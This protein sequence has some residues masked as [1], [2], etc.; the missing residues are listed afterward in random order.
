MKTPLWQ[1]TEERK[2]QANMTGFIRFVN[3]KHGLGLDGY[4]ELYGWS[5]A[6]IPDFWAAMWEFAGIRASRPYDRVVDDLAKFPGAKWFEGARLNFAQNLLRCRDDRTALIF[7]GET[8]KSE[9][10]TYAELYRAVSRLAGSL[11]ENGLQPGDRVAAY[12]PNLK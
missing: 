4:D 2:Q 6:K 12:L 8:Q 11:R 7:R 1:P 10:M 5:V 3:R 9:R